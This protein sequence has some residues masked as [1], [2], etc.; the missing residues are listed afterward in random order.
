[1]IDAINSNQKSSVEKCRSL[2]FDPMDEEHL[3]AIEAI[4]K[5]RAGL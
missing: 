5:R 1:M 2:I 4:A 3:G